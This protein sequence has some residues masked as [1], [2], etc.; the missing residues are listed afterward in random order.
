MSN[1]TPPS[2]FLIRVVFYGGSFVLAGFVW[3]WALDANVWYGVVPGAALGLVAGLI[4]GTTSKTGDWRP[5]KPNLPAWPYYGRRVAAGAVYHR[6]DSRVSNPAGNL[7]LGRLRACRNC[8]AHCTA[9]PI[10]PAE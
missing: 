5:R 4:L 7:T 2:L 10:G 3:A 1:Y 6:R 9:R 8:T